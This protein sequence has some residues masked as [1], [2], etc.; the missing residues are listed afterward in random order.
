MKTLII[1]SS[2]MLG[3]VL[4]KV[5]INESIEFITH[6]R[7]KENN[8]YIDEKNYKKELDL[9]LIT[10]KPKIIINLVAKTDILECEKNPQKAFQVNVDILKHLVV[11]IDKNK[12]HL[13]HISTDQV[14]SGIGPHTEK[15]V[16][17]CN[18][19]AITKYTSELI[20]KQVNSTILRTNFVG[21]SLIKK[22]LSLSDWVI[23]SFLKTKKKFTLYKDIR[24][25]PLHSNFLCKIISK[26]S[27]KQ[28]SGTFNLGSKNSIS[29]A[30]FA[31]A[32]A[33]KLNLRNDYV[34]INSYLN[35]NNA[36]KRPLDM[37]LDIKK[38]E[39]KFKIYLPTIEET[40]DQV[41]HDYLDL[42]DL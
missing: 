15:V 30:D 31:L 22:R 32:L 37:S 3:E 27:S 35:Q 1:G 9:K 39:K 24:F 28:I 14:Y 5:F 18:V 42:K 38:F 7:T 17:P 40:I 8:T 34:E 6:D 13:I 2:G 19:Y 21:R 10:Y 4:K 26:I 33:K 12:T 29:K 36:V 20:A 23:D 11:N 16:D 25:S 41:A